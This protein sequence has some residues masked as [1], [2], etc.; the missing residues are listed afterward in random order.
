MKWKD[1]HQR[2]SWIFCELLQVLFWSF[3]LLLSLQTHFTHTNTL[4][5]LA[6]GFFRSTLI[7]SRLSE[8]TLSFWNTILRPLPT[9]KAKFA[10][11]LEINPLDRA[12]R[13]KS[14]L[15]NVCIHVEALAGKTRSMILCGTTTLCLKKTRRKKLKEDKYCV[16]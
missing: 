10:I 9:S 5:K 13:S 8:P 7:L 6:V 2:M 11:R 3:S 16:V 14:A 4:S 12:R 15:L 1:L